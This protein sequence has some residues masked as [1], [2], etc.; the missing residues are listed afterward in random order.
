M[1]PLILKTIIFL[2]LT[3]FLLSGGLADSI[4]R[5]AQD[6]DYST[7]RVWDITSIEDVPALLE[8]MSDH[9]AVYDSTG[10]LHVAYGGDHLYYASCPSSVCTVEVV[11]PA[12]YVGSQAS[13]A[14]DSAGNPHIAYYSVGMSDYC[15]DEKIKYA[16]YDGAAW[17]IQDVI[18]DCVGA[19]PSLALDAQDVPHISY[20]HESSDELQIAD[21]DGDAWRTYTPA[22]LPAFDYSG[23]LSSFVSDPLGR[24]HLAFIAGEAGYGTVWYA[25]LDGGAWSPL[26]EVDNAPSAS[27]LALTL[28][29]SANP[30]L[31]YYKTYYD[32]DLSQNVSKLAYTYFD[33][34]TWQAVAEV[35]D[36]DYLGWTSIT[37]GTDN[38]P[39]LAYKANGSVAVVAKNGSGWGA[40]V[41]VPGSDEPERMYLGWRTPSRLGLAFLAEGALLQ[42]NTDATQTTWSTTTQI[43]ASGWVGSHIAMVADAAGNLHVTYTDQTETELRYAQRLVGGPWRYQSVLT[44]PE[45]YLIRAT[46]IDLDGE[47]NPQIV[48][49]LYDKVEQR[50][51]LKY[52]AWVNA[53][54]E[55]VPTGDPD[56]I[57]GCDPS[58]EL[59]SSG[60]IYIAYNRCDYINEN[61]WL[62]IYNGSWSTQLVDPDV[63]TGY[64]SLYVNEDG[65]MYI[66]YN[67]YEYPNGDLRYAYKEDSVN[68]NILDVTP[69]PYTYTGTSLAMDRFGRPRIAYVTQDG[70]YGDFLL[71]LASWNGFQW[72]VEPVTTTDTD[73]VFPH[74]A[75]DAQDK[76][77]LAFLT[78]RHPAYAV[79][80]GGEWAF[81]IPVDRPPLAPDFEFPATSNLSLAFGPTGD[82]VLV[83]DGEQDLKAAHMRLEFLTFLPLTVR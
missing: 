37:V 81:S 30:H 34:F 5:A 80:D 54:W 4:I 7:R 52:V 49:Q 48:Y 72:L 28:D 70:I 24:L 53:F 19:Q 64:P 41:E 50:S 74:L 46:D 43:D 42:A 35:A 62:A 23:T 75:I 29:N 61:L 14:L 79:K 12:D 60:A 15:N 27:G 68:W 59:N 1:R 55:P 51:A 26:V 31:S 66:S 73:F 36:M 6:I 17:H 56:D 16:S 63:D 18:E 25:M 47:N 83:Y 77:H 57:E 78:E 3:T 9:A 45:N 65:H 22:W 82:P 10:T 20:F 21:W 33:G 11:D 40:P 76:P 39:R 2:T 67:R 13:L 8:Q 44:A 71:N 38:Y 69:T 58:L 32:E